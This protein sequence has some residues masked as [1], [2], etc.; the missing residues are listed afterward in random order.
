ME[1]LYIEK[2]TV[3][4]NHPE[5]L[6][7]NRFK[8]VYMLWSTNASRRGRSNEQKHWVHP[9]FSTIFI[10]TMHNSVVSKRTF[11]LNIESS[12]ISRT[13]PHFGGT[14]EYMLCLARR[15][16]VENRKHRNWRKWYSMQIFLPSNGMIAKRVKFICAFVYDKL[17]ISCNNIY[18]SRIHS[19]Q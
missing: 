4:C 3:L 6:S 12:R 2:K 15:D 7:S 17:S 14:D 10:M 11:R 5:L 16:N 18:R 13:I 9:H 8:S 19:A 1:F